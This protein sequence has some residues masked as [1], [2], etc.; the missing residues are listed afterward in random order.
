[1]MA[2]KISVS[3][4]SAPVLSRPPRIN[5]ILAKEVDAALNQYFAERMIQDSTCPSSSPLV[6]MPKR[7][8]GVRITVTYK[9]LNQISSL[10]QLH[11]PRGPGPG[12]IGKGTGA[13]PVQRGFFVPSEFRAQE[14]NSC[15]GVLHSHGPV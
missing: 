3:E 15:H 10:S 14:H 1:M 12:L 8:R 6:V 9:N 7:S 13:F 2:F 11:P 5:P 4:G